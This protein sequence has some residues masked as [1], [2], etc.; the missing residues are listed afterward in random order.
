MIANWGRNRL[1]WASNPFAP[2]RSPACAALAVNCEKQKPGEWFRGTGEPVPDGRS[3]GRQGDVIRV[4][5]SRDPTTRRR[6]RTDNEKAAHVADLPRP[7]AGNLARETCLAIQPVERRLCVRDDGLHLDDE[8]RAERG[9]EGEHIDGPALAPDRK[10]DLDVDDPAEPRETGD[11]RINQCGVRL[12]QESI[13]LLAAP[14]QSQ[15]DVGAQGL[16]RSD[17]GPDSD[18]LEL[19]AVDGR[20]QRSRQTRITRDVRLTTL[21]SNPERAEL[22]TEPKAIHPAIVR[23]SALRAITR[24]LGVAMA[25]VPLI[26]QP[27]SPYPLARPAIRSIVLICQP[28]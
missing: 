1:P 26:R 4:P 2:S 17:E 18:T 20:N 25:P 13:Q 6:G 10:R 15:V 28:P 8:E 7:L 9:M 23:P 16:S 24:G 27:P 11:H 19:P 12:V 22:P 5:E 14:A 21:K 3:P